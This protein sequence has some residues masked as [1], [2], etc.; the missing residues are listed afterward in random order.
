MIIIIASAFVNGKTERERFSQKLKRP[1][2]RAPLE[3]SI[4]GDLSANSG[5]D[6]KI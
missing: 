2:A 4:P 5:K 1:R 6:I 3:L